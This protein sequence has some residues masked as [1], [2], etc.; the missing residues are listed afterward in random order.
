LDVELT[1]SL[2][3]LPH[4][5]HVTKPTLINLLG[6]W[7]GFAASK[8]ISLPLFSQQ[9][10]LKPKLS[11][12]EWVYWSPF[13]ILLK[14]TNIALANGCSENGSIFQHQKSLVVSL[15]HTGEMSDA[16]NSI[17]HRLFPR[18]NA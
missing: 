13:S 17:L 4:E 9:A 16:H 5:V 1:A 8:E 15:V 6:M 11:V 18:R 7:H 12:Y 3:K 14:V 2:F 10:W